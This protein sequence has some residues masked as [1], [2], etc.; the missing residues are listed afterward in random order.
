VFRSV[1][2]EVYRKSGDTQLPATFSTLREDFVLVAPNRKKSQQSRAVPEVSMRILSETKF[3]GLSVNLDQVVE[4]Y[5][6]YCSIVGNPDEDPFVRDQLIQCTGEKLLRAQDDLVKLRE[7]IQIHEELY[8]KGKDTERQNSARFLKAY[9]L[10]WSSTIFV[11]GTAA[12]SFL[13]MMILGSGHIMREMFPTSFIN[14][15][16]LRQAKQRDLVEKSYL[17]YRRD[18]E[19][20][21]RDFNNSLTNAGL[22]PQQTEVPSLADSAEVDDQQW[23]VKTSEKDI[24]LSPRALLSMLKRLKG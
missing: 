12:L 15:E 7:D 18:W 13:L 14:Y 23:E 19:K 2:E 5:S 17:Q 22:Q 10:L 11:T 3:R 24:L 20:A 4:P 1:R 6:K 21:Y 16:N 8:Q 9:L